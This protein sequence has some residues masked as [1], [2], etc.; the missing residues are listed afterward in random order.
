MSDFGLDATRVPVRF[1]QART[2]DILE[3]NLVREN[4]MTFEVL[5]LSAIIPSGGVA[6]EIQSMSI[7]SDLG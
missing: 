5:Q 7:V 4:A 2:V 1:A 3:T 6:S